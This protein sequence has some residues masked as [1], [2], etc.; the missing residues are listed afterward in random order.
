MHST[1][2]WVSSKQVEGFRAATFNISSSPTFKSTELF[3]EI[4]CLISQ[5]KKNK[6]RTWNIEY[7]CTF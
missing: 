3:L 2:V 4:F 1:G 7:N 5:T 6:N